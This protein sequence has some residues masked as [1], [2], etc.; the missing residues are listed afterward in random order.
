MRSRRLNFLWVCIDVQVHRHAV[1]TFCAILNCFFS[2]CFGGIMVIAL[3]RQCPTCDFISSSEDMISSMPHS[4][5]TMRTKFGERKSRTNSNVRSGCLRMRFSYR[6]IHRSILPIANC[7]GR[8][9]DLL[10]SKECSSSPQFVASRVHVVRRFLFHMKMLQ[11]FHRSFFLLPA[12]SSS[13]VRMLMS[14]Q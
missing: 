7:S 3:S 8:I 4:A 2:N 14:L 13:A 12:T 9:L 11:C 10:A 6:H 5:P 1:A